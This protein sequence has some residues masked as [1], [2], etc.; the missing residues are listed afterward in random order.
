MFSRTMTAALATAALAGAMMATGSNEAEARWRRG[1]Y[2][3]Y[4]GAVAA[5][6]VGGLAL[7]AIAASAAQPRPVYVEGGR[8]YKVR[9]SVWSDYH[10]A[11]VTRRVTVCD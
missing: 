9:R 5:G 1:Y 8:C 2:G 7:G 4:G 6:V 11:Y 10:G 3:G